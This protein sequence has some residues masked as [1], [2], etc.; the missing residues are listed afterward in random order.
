MQSRWKLCCV[1]LEALLSDVRVC[2]YKKITLLSH[3]ACYKANCFENQHK[4]LWHF[5]WTGSNL[6]LSSALIIIFA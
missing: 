5:F 4:I 6:G 1:F 3:F 2:D